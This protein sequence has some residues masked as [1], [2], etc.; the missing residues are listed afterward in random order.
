M[1]KHGHSMVEFPQLGV[2]SVP[3]FSNCLVIYGFQTLKMFEVKPTGGA[4]SK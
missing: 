4:G 1:D 2:E 3:Y